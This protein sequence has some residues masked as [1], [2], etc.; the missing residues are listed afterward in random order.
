MT[1]EKTHIKISGLKNTYEF[2]HISDS[3]ISTFT[4]DSN[5][6]EIEFAKKH[7]VQWSVPEIDQ[8]DAFC[9]AIKYADSINANGL[10]VT[11]DCVDFIYKPNLDY[12]KEKFAAM[13]TELLYVPGNHETGDYD[14]KPSRNGLLEPFIS[15]YNDVMF[16]DP[17]F[18]V[19][20]FGELLVIGIDDSARAV[21][22][23]QLTRLKE[24]SK[25]GL[26]IILLM[27]IPLNTEAITPAVIAKWGE[28]GLSHFTLGHEK[29]DDITKEFCKF[30]KSEESNVQAVIAGHSHFPENYHGEFA[31][32]RFQH[33]AVP[34]FTGV[35]NHYTVKK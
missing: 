11:G 28:G 32:G 2:V 9:D 8:K 33:V 3:H 19:K 26:P 20:D 22:E 24:Q 16:G 6:A 31:P 23:S 30:V 25:R 21:N 1:V 18:W 12:V 34:T 35:I 17:S 4:E 13:K 29:H 27:H 5:E 10:T 14:F 7:A 15:N